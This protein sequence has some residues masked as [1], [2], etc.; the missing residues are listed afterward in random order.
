MNDDDY[1]YYVES[2]GEQ[3]LTIL[4]TALAT[5]IIVGIMLLIAL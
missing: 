1:D 3:L 4:W 5:C 2:L